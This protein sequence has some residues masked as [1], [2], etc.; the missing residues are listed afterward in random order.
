MDFNQPFSVLNEKLRPRVTTSEQLYS[1]LTR[2]EGRQLGS[3]RNKYT[4]YRATVLPRE[5]E[6]NATTKTEDPEESVD[7][8][9][10]DYSKGNTGKNTCLINELN[11]ND[12]GEDELGDE[13]STS[14]S[15]EKDSMGEV[16][17]EE[18]R[19]SEELG[20]N[21]NTNSFQRDYLDGTLPDLLN[22]GKPL[23]RRRTLGHYSDTLKEV[24]REVELSRRRSIKLKAQVDKL[25]ESREG[26]GWSQHKDRV[27]EE[28]LSI[29]RLLHPLTEPESSQIEPPDGENRLDAA[30]AQLQNVA[31]KLAISHTKQESKPG[32]K[33]A[34]DSAILQQA[35]RDRDEAIEKKKAMEAELLR[36]KTEMMT[37]N[38]H[39]LEAAQ[40][41][42][43]LSLELEAW[44]EDFQLI[45]QQQVKSQ[46]QAEQNQKKP[47]R[48]GLLRRTNRA[49]MQRPTN[50]PVAGAATPANSSNQ[51][52][53]SKSA[54]SAAPAPK[55]PPTIGRSSNWRD[56]LR[57]GK[58]SRQGDQDLA[59][60]TEENDGFQVVSLD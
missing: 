8:T 56:K 51:N 11:L 47:S 23:S 17:S 15:D 45:L 29:L 53:T 18:A 14:Q 39:L 9:E 5:P 19:D 54:A 38:N 20:S 6:P 46:Q 28:V 30:L 3:L 7:E 16:A 25:Q 50:F 60:G 52:P 4:Y 21:E 41:R 2:L 22:S 33:V 57:M 44:K 40:K 34:E 24:R 48:M 13:E 10:K 31:R 35:L 26:Q 43:E 55:T 12:I 36:S 49:P 59:R 58:S 1:S 37:L 42:L 32:G 27:T